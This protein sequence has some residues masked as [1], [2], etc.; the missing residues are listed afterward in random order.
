MKLV[1]S[2]IILISA[3]F[4]S[5][6]AKAQSNYKPGYVVTSK[7]DTTKGYIDYREWDENPLEIRFRKTA[8]SEVEK[9]TPGNTLA[10]DITGLD[11]YE[12]Y[13]LHISQGRTEVSKMPVGVDTS[14]VAAQVFLQQVAAGKYVRLYSY[15]DHI[16]TRFYIKD[17]NDSKPDELI[18]QVYIN[19]ADLTQTVEQKKFQN[20]LYLLA[21]KY[22]NGDE[23][24]Y[25]KIESADYGQPEIKAIVDKINGMTGRAAKASGAGSTAF[26]AGIGV[27]KG[28]A[29]YS[30]N[31]AV[32]QG[33]SSQGSYSPL[34][35]VGVDV[36]LN[37]NVRRFLLRLELSFDAVNFNTVTHTPLYAQHTFDQYNAALTPQ[38][39]Y[40]LYNT[41]QFK[42]Y[43]GAGASINFSHYSNNDYKYANEPYSGT[44][45]ELRGYPALSTAWISF[46]G[47][48]GIVL[49]EKI[50]IY[51]GYAPP[52]SVT[53]HYTEMAAEIKTVRLGVNY[54]F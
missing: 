4:L 14:Y 26:F 43:L 5:L 1:Y 51:F 6:N 18:Y 45:D 2:T 17:N 12:S 10:F 54:L 33:A 30:G 34:V 20:Q 32:A 37:P 8:G 19:P 21:V 52:A 11:H 3:F 42:F 31:I 44:Y 13:N 9:F 47:K 48:A 16:K 27:L 35:D 15:K 24:L 49:H 7:G 46:I 40:N 25:K 28:S 38:I 29:S 53:D 39:I 50:D 22:D 41:D 23:K 36:F